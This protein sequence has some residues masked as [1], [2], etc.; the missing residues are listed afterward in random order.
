M[1]TVISEPAICSQVFLSSNHL[2]TRQH[3]LHRLFENMLAINRREYSLPL[4]IESVS[5]SASR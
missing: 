5:Y 1:N 3:F 4:Q 2:N